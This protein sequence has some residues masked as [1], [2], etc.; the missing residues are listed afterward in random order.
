M[1]IFVCLFVNS[2]FI[3][4]FPLGF[5]SVVN[6][7]EFLDIGVASNYLDMTPKVQTTKAKRSKWNC[8]K[9]TPLFLLQNKRNNQLKWEKN[10]CKS[11]S[12]RQSIAKICKKLMHTK[13]EQNNS[14]IIQLKIEKWPEIYIFPK[15]QRINQLVC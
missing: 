5:Q 10:I 4:L 7:K 13:T 1:I 14:Q 2:K 8:I 9:L 12:N 11:L 3:K 15:R 6:Q